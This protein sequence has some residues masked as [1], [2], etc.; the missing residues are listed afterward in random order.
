MVKFVILGFLTYKKLTGYDIKQTMIQSTSNFMNASFGSIYPALNSLEKG[1]LIDSTKVIENGKYK[2]IHEINEA[3]KEAFIKWLEEPIDFMK[4][5][6]DILAKTFFYGKLPKEKA[7]QL[8]EQ[9]IKDINKK[10]ENLENLETQIKDVAGYFEMSTLHFGVDHLKF[11]AKWYE[12][13]LDDFN[14]RE[15]EEIN[16]ECSNT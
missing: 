6:E 5:Y 3:G 16:D 10:I 13:F 4:S 1:G 14:K 15:E 11:M 12:K 2:K 7:S 9:L 8:I